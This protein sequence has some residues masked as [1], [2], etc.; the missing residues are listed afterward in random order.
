MQAGLFIVSGKF[1]AVSWPSGL[2]IYGTGE[3]GKPWRG[4]FYV[5]SD[6]RFRVPIGC[7][8]ILLTFSSVV[9]A[10][11]PPPL[12]KGTLCDETSWL[13]PTSL[14]QLGPDTTHYST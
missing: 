12:P 14:Y 11:A 3:P 4:K 8:H 6:N 5:W 1:C 2:S 9:W 10:S 13:L 7:W